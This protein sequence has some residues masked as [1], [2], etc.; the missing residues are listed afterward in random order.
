MYQFINSSWR[1]CSYHQSLGGGRDGG[2]ARGPGGARAGGGPG[3]G[4]MTTEGGTREGGV[5]RGPLEGGFVRGTELETRGLSS[6]A[7]GGADSE[8]E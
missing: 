3:G 1:C 6:T 7:G 4:A 8:F 2:G 5:V